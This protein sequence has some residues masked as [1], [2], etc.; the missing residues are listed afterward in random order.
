VLSVFVCENRSQFLSVASR[1]HD[2][3]AGTTVEFKLRPR[4]RAPLDV[5]ATVSGGPEL[6]WVLSPSC[7]TA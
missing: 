3:S 6:R 1:T 2:S 5:R 4:E 7:L